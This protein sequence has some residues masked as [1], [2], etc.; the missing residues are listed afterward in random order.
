MNR[1][2]EVNRK[3]WVYKKAGK[4]W[5]AAMKAAWADVIWSMDSLYAAA[6]VKPAEK[7]PYYQY[8]PKTAQGL[9]IYMA[10]YR[11]EAGITA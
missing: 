4:T 6:P 8:T 10:Q 2:S 5:S 1:M 7:K 9:A 3:A 11:K